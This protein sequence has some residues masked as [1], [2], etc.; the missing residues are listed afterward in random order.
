MVGIVFLRA[1]SGEHGLILCG[2]RPCEIAVLDLSFFCTQ[3]VHLQLGERAESCLR[4]HA[5]SVIHV[6]S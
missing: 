5:G 1:P 6:R 3:T 4:T 2:R